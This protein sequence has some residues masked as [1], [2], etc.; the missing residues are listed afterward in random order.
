[1]TVK[2]QWMLVLILSVALSVA[3][4]SIVLSLLINRYFV[5]YS[6]E[7]YKSH[8]SQ[9]EEL[10]KKVLVEKDYTKMQ[11]NMQLESHLSD[12]INEIKLYDNTGDLLA[13]AVSDNHQAMGMMR[14][15]MINRMM[16]N[17]AGEIDSIDI[18]QN[19]NVIGKLNITRYSS[20]GNSL[21]TRRFVVSLIGSSIMSFGM[22]FILIFFIGRVIS[23]KMS[24]DLRLT[25]EQAIDI[26]LGNTS[27]ITQSNVKEIRTIQQSLETLQARLKLKQTSRKKLMEELVHQTRTPLTILRTHLEGFQDGVIQLTPDEIKTCEVQIDNIT[28]IIT[29]MSG[30]IDAE[31]DID[32]I[33]IEQVELNPLLKQIVGGLKIQFEKKGIELELL[34]NEKLVLDTD[35]YKLSQVIY[36]LFTNAYKFTDTRGKVTVEYKKTEDNIEVSIMDSGVGISKEEQS[37]I[38]DAYYRGKNS[39][40]STGDGIGL[41]IAKENMM[42]IHG[43]IKVQSAPGKG[44]KFTIIIPEKHSKV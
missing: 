14:N 25:A 44:S 12:P 1:M 10:S 17:A 20:I 39:V 2:R 19:G 9:L 16:G 18:I 36:N 15:R 32:S 8:I 23:N 38:F 28:S 42:K 26:D 43:E 33:K 41:Y 37:K 27:H 6:T 22:V 5:D 35:R 31:K 11:I 24:K 7:N 4:N 29:N 21:G 40:D 34:N 30:M 3:V 13:E